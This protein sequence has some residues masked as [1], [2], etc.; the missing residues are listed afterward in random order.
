[1]ADIVLLSLVDFGGFIGLAI[2][3]TLPALLA[4]H[5]R[6]TAKLAN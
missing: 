2:P 1:M 3:E 4:W 6:A 5:G